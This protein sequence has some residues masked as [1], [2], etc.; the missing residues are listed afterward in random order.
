MGR[1]YGQVVSKLPR[2][3]A[4]GALSQVR[5]EQLNKCIIKLLPGCTVSEPHRENQAP[6]APMLGMQI[7][8]SIGAKNVS[9]RLRFTRALLHSKEVWMNFCLI[10]R[11]W[12]PYL[13]SRIR[14]KI[15]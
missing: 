8:V 7:R 14:G 15:P 4:M 11:V 2:A 3:T 9:D 10:L 5:E 13:S 1:G 6:C 12:V